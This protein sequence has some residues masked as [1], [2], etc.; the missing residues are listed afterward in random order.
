M[1]IIGL[2]IG[3][4]IL[5]IAIQSKSVLCVVLFL[6]LV[7]AMFFITVLPLKTVKQNTVEDYLRG[8]IEV[9]YQDIVTDSGRIISRDTVI[10]SKYKK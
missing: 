9:Q 4:I 6:I 10:V 2:V 8:N 3:F 5:Y 7:C 1:I